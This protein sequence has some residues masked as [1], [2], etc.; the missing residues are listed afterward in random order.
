MPV[1]DQTD[2]QAQQTQFEKSVFASSPTANDAQLNH[3]A[4]EQQIRINRAAQR[5]QF[6]LAASASEQPYINSNGTGLKFG[7][8]FFVGINGSWMLYDRDEAFSRTTALLAQQRIVETKLID[9][10]QQ[11]LNES[12]HDLDQID[13]GLRALAVLKKQL[14]QQQA[15][16][17]RIQVLQSTG[18]TEKTEVDAARSTLLN[19]RFEILQRQ[20]QVANGYYSFIS[21]LFRDPA[22][23]NSPPFTQPR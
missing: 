2:L 18:Q 4:L 17:G 7:T 13:L 12:A 20:V 11:S 21:E 22:L 6:N 1:V 16:Y 8:I 19:T 23:A 14:A 3:D 9:S 10:R 15:D 5:P